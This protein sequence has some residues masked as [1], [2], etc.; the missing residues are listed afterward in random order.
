METEI[1]LDTA[2]LGRMRPIAQ[3]ACRDFARL[4]GDEGGSVNIETFLR[5]GREAWPQSL[6]DR[7]PGLSAWTG[8]DGFKQAFRDLVRLPSE[9]NVWI[10]QRS[11]TLMQLAARAL[12]RRCERIF[13]TDLEWPPYLDVLRAEANCLGRELIE[14]PTRTAVFAEGIS[15]NELVQRLARLYRLSRSQGLFISDVSF[16]GVR[17]PTGQLLEVLVSGERPKFVVIDAAQGLGHVPPNFSVADLVLTGCHKWLEAGLPLCAA[18]GPKKRSQSFLATLVAEMINDGKLDDPILSF[19]KQLDLGRN[20]VYEIGVAETINL[21]SLFSA[22][23]IVEQRLEQEKLRIRLEA[24]DGPP[25]SPD[26]GL[27][28]EL[29]ARVTES[30][31]LAALADS[32]G[33]TAL[34]SHLDQRSGILLLQPRM[35][36]KNS[37]SPS[38]LRKQFQDY[39]IA[40]SVLPYCVLRV[41]LQA[42]PCSED[43][44]RQ[45]T[46]AMTDGFAL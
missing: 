45:L 4:C 35:R 26:S 32:V 27:S 10:S 8:V 28:L 40:L 39:G 21:V 15:A 3:A 24:T 5:E 31:K 42:M 41:S 16:E 17:L 22:G 20:E 34:R 25:E 44:L 43:A 6:Q 37:V 7:Y 14:A 23:T 19:L 9:T 2:R 29:A 13:H 11:K 12:C 38:A 30:E 33:W 18:F 36:S 46:I 1:Y